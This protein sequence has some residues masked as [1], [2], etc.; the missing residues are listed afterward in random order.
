MRHHRRLTGTPS[1]RGLIF[2]ST[3]SAHPIV[4]N[5]RRQAGRIATIFVRGGGLERRA[6]SEAQVTFPLRTGTGFWLDVDGDWE[7]GADEPE[8][9]LNLIAAVTVPNEGGEEGRVVVIADADFVSDVVLR[10]P[11]NALVFGDV[12][13]WFLGEEEIIGDTATEEDVRIEHTRDE[14]KVWFYGTSFGAPLPLLLLGLWMAL[15]RRRRR[16]THQPEASTAS[17]APIVSASEEAVEEARA[18]EPKREPEAEIQPDSGSE[19]D[20]ES[21]KPAK[22]DSEGELGKGDDGLTDA[23]AESGGAS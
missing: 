21:G 7:R 8:A 2:S 18:D 19:E 20:E 9:E 13:Q 4:T 11:G 23:D 14:D 17:D 1:D 3:Y 12:M 10:N 22:A 16:E 15:R 5:A 6:G